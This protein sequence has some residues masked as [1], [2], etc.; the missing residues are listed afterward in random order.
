EELS[1]IKECV[2]EVSLKREKRLFSTGDSGDEMFLVRRGGVR[3]LLPVAEGK[4]RHLA[5]V[6]QGGFFGEL[7]FIDNETRSTDVDAKSDTDLYVLSRR[8]FNECSRANAT[9]GVLVFARL[10]KAIALRLRDTN[11]RIE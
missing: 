5:T 10:A 7:A 6:S 9:I 11:A 1:N 8:R 4:Y 3:I 2:S